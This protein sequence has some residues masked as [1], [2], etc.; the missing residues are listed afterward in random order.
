VLPWRDVLHDGP[1]RPDADR[2]A[3]AEARVAFLADRKWGTPA[4]LRAAFAERDARLEA[5]TTSDLVVLWFEPDLYD[6][7]QLM[8]VLAR[9]SARAVADRPALCTV[10]PIISSAR[11]P[12]RGICR[13]TLNGVR[14]PMGT[15]STAGPRGTRSRP[16]TQ[17]P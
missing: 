8:Q 17:A 5:C 6:Q 7:L 12:P 16:R 15:V 10:P 11:W 4:A 14:S 9:F 1:V 13:S 3:F 2:Y